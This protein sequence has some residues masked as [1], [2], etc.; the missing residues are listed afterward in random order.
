[1]TLL[2]DEQDGASAPAASRIPTRTDVYVPGRPPGNYYIAGPQLPGETG[3]SRVRQ[4]QG[5]TGNR[6]ELSP[7]SPRSAA[8]ASSAALSVPRRP[9]ALRSRVQSLSVTRCNRMVPTSQA[10]ADGEGR[11]VLP[12]PF[13]IAQ[14]Y[15]RDATGKLGGFRGDR[16]DQNGE[17]TVVARPAAI[18]H[19]RVVDAVR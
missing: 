5:R 12:R 19:G 11:F 16:R 18:A 14:I 1:M 2:E 3:K 13:G 8:E 10:F 6:K 17:V 7:F 4:G 15:A 9:T